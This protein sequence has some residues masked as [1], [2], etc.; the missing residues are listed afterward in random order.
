MDANVVIIPNIFEARDN[1][2]DK[3]K[4]SAKTLVTS[5]SQNHP[6]CRWG[7]TFEKTLKMLKIEAKPHDL[8]VTMGAG[9]VYQIG[10]S[11]LIL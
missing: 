5:I 11:F 8:I 10:E 1:Q 2:E 6:N 9:D 3:A 4:I 7:E